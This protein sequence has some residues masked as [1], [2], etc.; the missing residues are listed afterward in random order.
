M[1][2]TFNDTVLYVSFYLLPAEIKLWNSHTV[3]NK[4]CKYIQAKCSV[5][6]CNF[7]INQNCSYEMML[8]TGIVF[9]VI[10]HIMSDL[11]L[12]QMMHVEQSLQSKVTHIPILL[13][14]DVKASDFN[15]L[16]FTAGQ[17]QSMGWLPV[18]EKQEYQMQS[19]NQWIIM[20][21][22]GDIFQQ[23]MAASSWESTAFWW[24]LWVRETKGQCWAYVAFFLF[25]LLCEMIMCLHL[26]KTLKASR[27][28]F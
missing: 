4:V 13:L 11:K 8:Q 17:L 20:A 14:L 3:Q 21:F 16:M 10:S 24:I 12:G 23:Y 26:N 5:I 1:W 7:S 6:Q 9:L 2:T 22:T 28:H 18:F 25:F 15:C 27:C 19:W